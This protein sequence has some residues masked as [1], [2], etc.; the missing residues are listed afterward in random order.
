VLHPLVVHMTLA[1]EVGVECFDVRR[2]LVRT[3]AVA[4]VF[5]GA[6][7]QPAVGYFR[8]LTIQ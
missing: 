2:L 3:L 5:H 1:Q 8:T 4:I 6:K 7:H